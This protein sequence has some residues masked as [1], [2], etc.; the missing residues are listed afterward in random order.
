MNLTLIASILHI[1]VFVGVVIGFIFVLRSEHSHERA[2]FRPVGRIYS[3]T[4]L[5][6]GVLGMLLGIFMAYTSDTSS[7]S[8]LGPVFMG[9]LVGGVIGLLVQFLITRHLL[10][11]GLAFE[12]AL[13]HATSW[14][15]KRPCNAEV[16]AAFLTI[17]L[18]LVVCVG[19]TAAL[20]VIF[21]A[22]PNLDYLEETKGSSTL[23]AIGLTIFAFVVLAPLYEEI[24]FRGLLQSGLTWIMLPWTEHAGIIFT[25]I[26]FALIHGAMLE[27]EWLKLVQILPLGIFLGYIR[28][29]HGL[30][31][32]IIFHVL[33][34]GIALIIGQVFWPDIA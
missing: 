15:Y 27:P 19:W 11:A 9:T 4:Q 6:V 26:I 14:L 12:E 20:F 8:M 31:A 25:A 13:G 16:K 17:A 34:N 2:S 5:L 21:D 32:C 7:N 28:R 30:E 23:L 10:P 22:Q 33:F 24:L 18:G 3:V 1:L 29:Y